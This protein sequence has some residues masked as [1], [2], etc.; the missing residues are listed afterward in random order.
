MFLDHIIFTFYLSLV[1]WVGCV[2]WLLGGGFQRWGIDILS[3]SE[4]GTFSRVVPNLGHKTNFFPIV[5]INM[6]LF[7]VLV[8]WDK[9]RSIGK[10]T[11]KY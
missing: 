11:E 1:T 7:E 10:F 9:L 8:Q 6:K 4:S 5:T 2:S 3:S